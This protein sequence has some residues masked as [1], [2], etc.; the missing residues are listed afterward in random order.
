MKTKSSKSKLGFDNFIK[1]QL[2]CG[3]ASPHH[4]KAAFYF[5]ASPKGLNALL[6][7]LMFVSLGSLSFLPLFTPLA[8]A[9]INDQ[10]NTNGLNERQIATLKSLGIAIAVPS[11]IPKGFHVSDVQI[12]PCPADAKKDTN[13]VCRFEPSYTI[14]YRNLKNNCFEVNAIGGGIGGPDGKYSRKVNSQILGEIDLNIDVSRGQSSQP[15]SES[16]GKSPQA[17]MWTF[18]A[19]NSPYY[20]VAT[21]EGKRFQNDKSTF[22]SY[23]AYMTPD[24]LTK[25]VQSLE[26]LR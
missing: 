20:Q 17:N 11:Y 8:N 12:T 21:I 13:G 2:F 6:I 18:P 14:V 19:G 22:C 15:I 26:W 3:A 4:K 24:E 10:V 23:K 9:Q 1:N 7:S 5:T 16:L 25:I